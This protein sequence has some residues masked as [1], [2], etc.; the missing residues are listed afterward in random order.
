MYT[1]RHLLLTTLAL[2]AGKSVHVAGQDHDPSVRRVPVTARKYAF[3][4]PRI[5]VAQDDLVRIELRTLDIAHSMTIDAYR[6]SKRVSP[7]A[8]VTFEFRADREGTFPF[9]CN[10]QIDDGCRQ[11]RGELIVRPRR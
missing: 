10:L 6:I 2:A 1:R 9:Y 7:G 5:E 3:D 4:P 11:M 8:P